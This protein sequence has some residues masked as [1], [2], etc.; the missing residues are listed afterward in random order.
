M[1]EQLIPPVNCGKGCM[2]LSFILICGLLFATIID[3]VGCEFWRQQV[4]MGD[5]KTGLKYV[6]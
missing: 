5:A 3:H 1:I 4:Q 2:S 6:H